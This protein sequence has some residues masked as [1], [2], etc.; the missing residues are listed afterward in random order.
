MSE[1]EFD[2]SEIWLFWAIVLVLYLLGTAM[3]NFGWVIV[4][5]APIF[6]ASVTGL[7]VLLGRAYLKSEWRHYRMARRDIRRAISWGLKKIDQ[8]SGA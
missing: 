1:D 7:A 3:Y 2:N 8:V 5:L 6:V 4:V